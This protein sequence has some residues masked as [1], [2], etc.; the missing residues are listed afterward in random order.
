MALA[1]TLLAV[2]VVV[3]VSVLL[4]RRVQH[5]EQ[6]ATHAGEGPDRDVTTGRLEDGVDRPAGPDAEDPVGPTRAGDEPPPDT[7]RA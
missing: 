7:G 1:L 2:V 5:P 6:T 4:A 3:A